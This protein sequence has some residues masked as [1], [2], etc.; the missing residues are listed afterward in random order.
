MIVTQHPKYTDTMQQQLIYNILK[1]LFKRFR[2]LEDLKPY[3]AY[4]CYPNLGALSLLLYEVGETKTIWSPS[5]MNYDLFYH[6]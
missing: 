6:I 4:L 5:F 2:D 3:K 1:D